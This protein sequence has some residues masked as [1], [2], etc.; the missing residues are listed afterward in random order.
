MTTLATKNLTVSIAD[1]VL[2]REFNITFLPGEIWGILGPNG[3]GKTTFLHTLAGLHEPTTGKVSLNDTDI[4]KIKPKMRAQ[5]IGLLLQDTEFLFPSTVLETAMMG[6]YPYSKHWFYTPNDDIK[7]TKQSLAHTQLT[8]FEQRSIT[9]LS[10]GEKRRLAL[11]TLLTQDPDIY[12]LD[13]PT[14]HLD[15]QQ[16]VKALSLLRDLA[17]QKNKTVIMILHDLHLIRMFCDN[18]ILMG[19][20][21]KNIFGPCADLLDD[22]ILGQFFPE[23]VLEIYSNI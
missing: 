5:K 16:K 13:E 18:L 1:N 23:E 15:I 20:N 7:I 14:N 9:T 2:L 17:K 19:T 11:A 22:K 8:S 21:G 4:Q 12:L 10:G 3:A 6:R